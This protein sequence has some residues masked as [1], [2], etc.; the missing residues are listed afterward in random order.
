MTSSVK[1]SAHCASNKKVK[2]SVTENGDNHPNIYLK[3]GE[4]TE[5]SFYD[6]KAVTVQEVL[7]ED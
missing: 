2:I 3:D 6:T 1:I 7:V 4:V 5:I